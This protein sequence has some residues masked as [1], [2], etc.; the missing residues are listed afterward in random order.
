MASPLLL[1]IYDRTWVYRTYYLIVRSFKEYWNEDR[2]LKYLDMVKNGRAK[3]LINDKDLMDRITR[4]TNED[5]EESGRSIAEIN[6]TEEEREVGV[7][8]RI[9]GHFNDVLNSFKV[10]ADI[11]GQ[12]VPRLHAHWYMKIHEDEDE[13]LQQ[14]SLLFE[15]VVG[16]NL[17]NLFDNAPE[18]AWCDIGDKVLEVVNLISDRGVLNMW[19]TLNSFTIRTMTAEDGTVAYMPVMTD[20]NSCRIRRQDETE[21][22]WRR[23]KRYVDEEGQVGLQLVTMFK[24]AGHEYRYK[25]S[26]RYHR[27]KREIADYRLIK[28]KP[29]LN[30]FSDRG[31]RMKIQ[32]GGYTL[33]CPY[34]EDSII[35]LMVTNSVSMSTPTSSK[36]R[37]RVVKL[38]QPV[39]ISPVMLVEVEGECKTMVLKLFDRRCCP[40]LRNDVPRD[41][42]ED[43]EDEYK[44]FVESGEADGFKKG[45][46]PFEFGQLEWS[47]AQ[48]EKL[49]YDEC[50]E[51]YAS[52]VKAYESLRC[53][54]GKNIPKL[55]ATVTLQYDS[56]SNNEYQHYFEAPGILM[57]YIQ[58]INLMDICDHLDSSLWV[59]IVESATSLVRRMGELNFINYDLKPSHVIVREVNDQNEPRY[60]PVMI[61][62]AL[63]RIHGED[64]SD[65]NWYE[66]KFNWDEENVI[67]QIMSRIFSSKGLDWRHKNIYRYFRDDNGIVHPIDN[68]TMNDINK[69]KNS[70]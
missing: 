23:A 14:P 40:G 7:F 69:Y 46:T 17:V 24:N 4:E 10:L 15:D 61:D 59:S 66:D 65:E 68:K 60:E 70:F 8:Y 42:N 48:D 58:G 32:E 56:S 28:Y 64:D 57:E 52:E 53:I 44:S 37:A 33:D 31:L 5:D 47:V 1:L 41:W 20:V 63:S 34:R 36:I 22:K 50:Q 43:V 12:Y 27:S 11:Q 2:E 45:Y 21:E 35:E 3:S 55:F 9:Q 30:R 51:L 38:F 29:F 19:Y 26:F 13:M 18:S 6:W 54:Q 49:L 62:F 39:T 16:F 67:G 25:P